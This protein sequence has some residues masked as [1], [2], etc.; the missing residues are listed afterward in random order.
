MSVQVEN[1]DKN[2]AKLTIEVSAEEFENAVER[3]YSKQKNRI[4]IPGF[5]KGKA[6]RKMIEKM[7][8]A[9]IF[10][11]DAANAI[12]PDAYENA[13]K[14]SGLEI[15]SQPDVNVTQIEAGKPFI[16]TAEVA[17]KPE[18][19]LGEYKGIEVGKVITE[20]TDEDLQAELDKVREQQSRVVSVEDKAAENGDIVVIDFEGFRDGVAFEGGKG[21]DYPLTLGSH[22]FIDTFED[23]L[24]GKKAGDETE[25][26]VTFP[27]EYQE[28]SLAGQSAMFKVKVKEVKVKELPELDDDFAQDVSEFDTLEEYKEDLKKQL[29]ERREKTAKDAKEDAV[30]E[31]IVENAQ[32]DIPEAMV[33]TQMNQMANDFSQRI[34]SQGISMEQ[35]FQFTGLDNAKFGEQIR[36]Q[37]LKR[38]QSRLVLEAI[39]KA[40]NIEVSEDELNKEIENMAAAYQME[41]D[42]VREMIGDEYK[43]SMKLDI[44]VQKAVDLVVEASVEKEGIVNENTAE[45]V[46][47]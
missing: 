9:G 4:N 17:V 6:P 34:Q 11:E 39:A 3:A 25:V 21:E 37:A 19:T 32:M 15:V 13:A 1:L 31:K 20:V 40:E 36:P 24:V 7:Y 41:A 44:A 14:E 5:R 35:Y 18:V 28:E 46:E 43:E 16:F 27:E 42:K 26:N 30:I 33:R 8:G 12:I 2:M 23:Q 29:L 10:Y 45:S 22:S 47:E 38:I